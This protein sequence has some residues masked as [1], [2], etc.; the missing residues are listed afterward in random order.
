MGLVP[1]FCTAAGRVVRPGVTAGWLEDRDRAGLF[2]AQS[3]ALTEMLVLSPE[4]GARF[5]AL[6]AA[7]SL[8]EASV[9]TLASVN[10]KSL[11]AIARDVHAWVDARPR[12]TPVAL[13]GVAAGVGAVDVVDVSPFAARSLLAEL[14]LASGNLERAEALYGDLAR[15]VPDAADVSAAL[16]AIAL[17][18]GDSAGARE[19]WKR[20]IRQGIRDASLCYSYATLAGMAGLPADEVR[21]ALERAIALKP[22]FDDARYTLALLEKNAGHYDV[23]LEQL[24]A[25]RGVAPVRAYN[26]WITLADTLRE[27]ERRE[28]ATVAA[29]EDTETGGPPAERARAA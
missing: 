1:R 16:G 19:Q 12:F 24:P 18:K 2:Y 8:G 17:R 20:A 4:Y 9:A 29:Q 28:E 26:Y 22:D 13:P 14:V 5:P 21:P 7:L 10:G 15:E 25:M 11:E 27:L 6:I 3:G 23:A